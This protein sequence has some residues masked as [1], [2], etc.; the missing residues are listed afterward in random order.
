M[1][2]TRIAI[3]TGTLAL[4]GCSDKWTKYGVTD[5]HA[6]MDLYQCQRENENVSDGSVVGPNGDFAQ[7]ELIRQCMRAHGYKPQ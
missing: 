1:T 7:E 2:K 4:V 3:L 6:D 5:Q